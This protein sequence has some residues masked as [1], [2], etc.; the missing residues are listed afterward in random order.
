[1]DDGEI[2]RLFF[3]LSDGM[4][5]QV[6]AEVTNHVHEI[7]FAARFFDVTPT[8]HEFLENFVAVNKAE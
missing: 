3:P 2:L 5:V 8:Q 4:K 1:V 7:G 6:F